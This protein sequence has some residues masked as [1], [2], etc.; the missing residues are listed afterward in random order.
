MEQKN[1]KSTKIS[2]YTLALLQWLKFLTVGV[3]FSGLSV[4][5]AACTIVSSSLYNSLFPLTYS[6]Y[7]GLCFFMMGVCSILVIPP[8]L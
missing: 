2:Q 3:M 1:T 5:E 7:P 8:M 4:I 6:L